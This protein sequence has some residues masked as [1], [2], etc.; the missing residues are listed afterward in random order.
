MEQDRPQRRVSRRTILRAGLAGT[1]A[2]LLAACGAGTAAEPSAAAP[3]AAAPSAAA[4]SV[5]ASEA[6]SAAA[7]VAASEAASTA[8]SAA[9]STAASTAPSAAASAAASE[10]ASAAPSAEAV[11]PQ[12]GAGKLAVLQRQEYFKGVETKFRETVQ[13]YVDSQGATLDISTV[14]PENFG[15]FTAKMQAAVQAGNP[16]DLVYQTN[17]SPQQLYFLDLLENVNDVVEASVA[18]HGDIV[19]LQ[20]EKNA[21]IDDVWWSVPFFSTTGAWFA[22]KDLFEAKGIDFLTLDTLQKRRDAALQVSDPDNEVWGWG[23]TINKSGDGHGVILAA[24]HTFGGRMVDETGEKVMINSPETV[25][26][27]KW[28]AETYTA[29]QFKPMLPPGIESWTDPSNNEAFLAGKTALTS[30]AFSIYATA[31]SENNPIFP[32]IGLLYFP[33][34]NDGIVLGGGSSGWFHIMRG[35]VNP[36]LAKGT[37]EHML[38]PENLIPLVQEGGGLILPAYKNSWTDEVLALDPNYATLQKIIYEETAYTGFPYPADP[39]PATSAADA[40]GFQSEMMANVTSGRMTAE[41][42][43]TDAHSKIV[44]IFEELGLPQS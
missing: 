13:A 44:A 27:V 35:A 9:A 33:V 12:G 36:D 41:E 40:S 6:A 29:E 3:S 24:I 21:R 32:N 37:I 14:N 18:A 23:A 7:S 20:A 43:V 19:P 34:A 38:L 8:A 1:G 31:K 26:A 5:A 17:T 10:A 2:A 30:N 42:A 15:D 25:E 4:P 22:R 16:P 39:N 28:L 11:V